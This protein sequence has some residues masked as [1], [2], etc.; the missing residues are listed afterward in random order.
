MT[1]WLMT[2]MKHWMKWMKDHCLYQKLNF[3]NQLKRKGSGKLQTYWRDILQLL[4]ITWFEF[5]R[6][7]HKNTKF[8]LTIIKIESFKSLY[9][10]LYRVAPCDLTRQTSG[11]L[12][13]CSCRPGRPAPAS[14]AG[15]LSAISH[16]GF[17][18]PV[19]GKCR[20]YKNNFRH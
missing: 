12:V 7:S 15:Q 8:A 11:Q 14:Q 19:S 4:L 3:I 10:I 9:F 16:Q 1:W 5:E 13:K 2:T 6:C 17:N 18:F 20:S